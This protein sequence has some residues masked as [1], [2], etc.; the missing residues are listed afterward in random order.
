MAARR[1]RESSQALVDRDAFIKEEEDLS[2][3]KKF[4]AKQIH[5]LKGMLAGT[6]NL[7]FNF[8]FQTFSSNQFPKSTRKDLLIFKAVDY[9]FICIFL[10]C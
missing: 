3:Q 8:K 6:S 7:I 2:D 10:Q 1:S 5:V 9:E 4:A